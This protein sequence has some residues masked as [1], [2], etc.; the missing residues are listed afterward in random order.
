M[1]GP[2]DTGRWGGSPLSPRPPPSAAQ[3]RGVPPFPP[4]GG[5]GGGDGE[6]RWPGGAASENTTGRRHGERGC[7]CV[8]LAG[9]GQHCPRGTSGTGTATRRR[10]VRRAPGVLGDPSQRGCQDACSCALYV[11]GTC[12]SSLFSLCIALA[13]LPPILVG[14]VNFIKTFLRR[15]FDPFCIFIRCHRTNS[16]ERITAGVKYLPFIISLKEE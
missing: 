14:G 1:R 13:W 10:R 5:R 12:I 16:P 2:G 15:L 7:P 6:A 4:R 9:H 11:R 3:T 8:G